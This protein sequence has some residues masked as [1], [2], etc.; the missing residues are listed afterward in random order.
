MRPCGEQATP[1]E[2]R[3]QT[4]ADIVYYDDEWDKA[5]DAVG[6]MEAGYGPLTLRLTPASLPCSAAYK[7]ESTYIECIGYWRDDFSGYR[8]THAA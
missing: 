7:L 1:D 3:R 5:L 6:V 2:L 8:Y 4:G